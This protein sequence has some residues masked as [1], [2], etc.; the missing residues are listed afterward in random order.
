MTLAEARRRY[1]DENEFGAD[2][3][4][5]EAWVD[6][7]LGPV[8]FP[9]PNTAPRVRAVRYHDLHHLVTGYET[10]FVGELEISAW[11]IGSGCATMIAAW[12]LNL[13]GMGLGALVAP[14]ETWAAFVLGRRTKNFYREPFDDALLALTVGEARRRLRLDAP[15]ARAG[16]ATRRDAVAFAVASVVGLGVALSSILLFAPIALIAAC[17]IGASGGRTS[18]E[19]RSSRSRAPSAAREGDF[20][21]RG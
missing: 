16:R 8:W 19:A 12:Y 3:G 15:S 4:Y 11:E 20:S 1:F 21:P 18:T 6:F 10:S 9:F 5:E 13:A 17:A 7:M 14:R 2:G